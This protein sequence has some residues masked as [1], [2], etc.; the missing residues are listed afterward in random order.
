MQPW[1]RANAR[2]GKQQIPPISISKWCR[3]IAGSDCAASSV[4]SIDCA[5]GNGDHCLAHLCD[6]SWTNKLIGAKDHGSIQINIGHLDS[7]GV[8]TTQFTTFAISGTVRGR[9]EAD[10]AIDLLWAKKKMELES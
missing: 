2:C 1:H 7:D 9:G 8:Y 3:C 6:S 10:S 4:A 5:S